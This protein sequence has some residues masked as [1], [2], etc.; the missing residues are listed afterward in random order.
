SALPLIFTG[1]RLSLG[2]GARM[3][4]PF[5]WAPGWN[6]HQAW[7]KF[8]DEVG[9]HLR[10]GDPG[11]RLVM[12]RSGAYDYSRDVPAA[13]K[14]RSNGWQLLVLPRLFGGEETSARA[15]PIE[16]RASV[17]SEAPSIGLSSDDAAQLGLEQ[18]ALLTLA[19]DT[20]SLTLPLR[21]DQRLPSGVVSLPAGLSSEF[22]SG[23]WARINAPAPGAASSHEEAPL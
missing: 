22:R 16:E 13:F 12:P 11:V 18:G 15:T 3:E 7:N 23:E 19:T 9:G 20:A 4:V 17:P 5:A 10:A 1:L 2:V 21:C 6:S 14:P 8:T